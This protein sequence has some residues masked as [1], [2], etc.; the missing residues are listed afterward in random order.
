MVGIAF[1]DISFYVFLFLSINEFTYGNLGVRTEDRSGSRSWL[2]G[3]GEAGIRVGVACW[4]ITS[5]LRRNAVLRSGGSEGCKDRSG[6]EALGQHLEVEFG[7][8]CC[9]AE[10]MDTGSSYIQ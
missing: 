2:E 3:N 8:S 4:Y 1:E 10:T 5:L 7:S 9:A 6:E